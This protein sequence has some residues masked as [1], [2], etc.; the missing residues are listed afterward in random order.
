ML[1]KKKKIHVPTYRTN[2]SF[3]DLEM[4]DVRLFEPVWWFNT[5]PIHQEIWRFSG[6][7]NLADKSIF[8]FL[9]AENYNF[10]MLA[11]QIK[12]VY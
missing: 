1:F 8:R 11:I 9:G 10:H 2:T 7:E 3:F 4:D 12:I 5:Y 6:A